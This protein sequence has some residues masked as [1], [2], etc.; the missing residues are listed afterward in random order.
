MEKAHTTMR[1]TAKESV[2]QELQN[3]DIGLIGL[4]IGRNRDAGSQQ[5]GE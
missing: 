5:S 4:M 3:I 1:T 2:C